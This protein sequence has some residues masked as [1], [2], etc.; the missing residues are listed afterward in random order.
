VTRVGRESAFCSAVLIGLLLFIVCLSPLEYAARFLHPFI[1][2][3]TVVG[4]ILLARIREELEDGGRPELSRRAARWVAAVVVALAAVQL[5][6]DIVQVRREWL[7]ASMGPD[8]AAWSRLRRELP[9]AGCSLADYPSY[10]AWHTGRCFIWYPADQDFGPLSAD[11]GRRRAVI[12]TRDRG[13]A[14]GDPTGIPSTVVLAERLL[15][16][17]W[18]RKEI[19]GLDLFPGSP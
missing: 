16:G 11:A 19:G 5:I 1:P 2:A 9:A 4:V 3:L 12:L 10:Y 18:T 8:G 17:G 7:R 14:G 6:G 13:R 15:A